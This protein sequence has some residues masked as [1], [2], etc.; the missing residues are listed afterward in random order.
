MIKAPQDFGAGMVFLGAGVFV[1]ATAWDYPLGSASRMS[2]GYMPMLLGGA[3]CLVGAT[4]ALR[5]LWIAGAPLPRLAPRPLLA[6]LAVVIFGLLL[7]PAGLILATL[8]LIVVSVMATRRFR[9]ADMAL[10][11]LLL[12]PFNWLV[13]VRA[14]GLPLPLTPWG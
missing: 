7:R 8:A 6:L 10:L 9:W 2:Y 5:A 13:F 11:S 1:I 12:I 14:L 4:I 3:L